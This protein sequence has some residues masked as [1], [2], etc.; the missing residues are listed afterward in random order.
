MRG[1]GS[2]GGFLIPSI[3]P[4]SV[5][6]ATGTAAACLLLA[7]AA[8]GAGLVG[9]RGW[10]DAGVEG[11]AA[12]A[13]EGRVGSSCALDS[14]GAPNTD[15]SSLASIGALSST[16]LEPPG[17]AEAGADDCGLYGSLRAIQTRVLVCC[18]VVIVDETIT[19]TLQP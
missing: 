13:E 14:A 6:V 19:L 4:L 11:G 15:A 5:P 17:S 1:L 18:T 10:T 8:V 7:C 12:P 3:A 9:N 16:E 2:L